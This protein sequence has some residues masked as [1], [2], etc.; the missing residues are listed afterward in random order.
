MSWDERSHPLPDRDWIDIAI[1]RADE[2][3]NGT[4]TPVSHAEA[5]RSARAAIVEQSRR[6]R[7]ALCLVFHEEPKSSDGFRLFKAIADVLKPLG[8][9]QGQPGLYFGNL[10]VTPVTC[11]LGV[12]ELTRRLEWFRTSVSSLQMLRIDECNDLMPAVQQ[13]TET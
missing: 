7:Y 10:E 12:M 9:T 3:E 6:P 11:V 8:F 4:A 2:L 5:M 1:R 13:A